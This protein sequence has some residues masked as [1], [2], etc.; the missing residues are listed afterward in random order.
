MWDFQLQLHTNGGKWGIWGR[1]ATVGDS[2][3]LFRDLELPTQ[4]I[5]QLHHG[6]NCVWITDTLAVPTPVEHCEAEKGRH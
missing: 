3:F 1:S 2:I 5:G 6:A 4:A